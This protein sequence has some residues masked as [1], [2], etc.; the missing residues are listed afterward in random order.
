MAVLSNPTSA[1]PY[2]VVDILGDYTVELTVTDPWKASKK[3]S[4]KVS[5]ANTRPVANAG[6]NATGTVGQTAY[7]DGS[8]SYDANGDSLTY[9]W[10][11][12]FKPSGSS[13]MLSMA[14][15]VRPS[16]VPDL[17][18]TYVVS[19]I[20]N[21]GRE[22]SSPSSVT[23][24]VIQ[25]VSAATAKLQQAIDLVHTLDKSAFKNANM[26]NA[27]INKINAVIQNIDEGVIAEA[28]GQLQNDLLQK[29]NGCA[30]SGAPD[31]NDWIIACAVQGQIY[32]LIQEAILILQSY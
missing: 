13:A 21:D 26:P 20:V 14:G 12:P 4:M 25:S 8:G 32:P 11:F 24:T 17:T 2:F 19:L 22:N 1:T 23:I 31:A 15:S 28:L 6:G 29:M 10:S 5:F 30:D 16:F 18:G 7:L 3:D 9:S 27:L